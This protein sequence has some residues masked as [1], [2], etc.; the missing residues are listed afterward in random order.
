[1]NAAIRVGEQIYVDLICRICTTRLFPLC[2]YLFKKGKE[3][4]TGRD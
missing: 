3:H 2:L 4:G 1:M